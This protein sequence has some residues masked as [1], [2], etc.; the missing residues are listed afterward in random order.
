MSD[1]RQSRVA[2]TLPPLVLLILVAA[3]AVGVQSYASPEG[4]LQLPTA[5]MGDGDPRI[6]TGSYAYPREELDSDDFVVKIAHPPRRIVSQYWSIDEYVYSVVPPQDV[7]AV[8]E[9]A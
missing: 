9:S 3:L 8:S 2:R 5:T 1:S 7:V 6:R 4:G